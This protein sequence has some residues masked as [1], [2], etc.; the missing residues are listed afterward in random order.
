MSILIF[1]LYSCE[2]PELAKCPKCV[3]PL[4]QKIEEQT[5]KFINAFSASSPMNPLYGVAA[6]A[7]EAVSGGLDTNPATALKQFQADMKQYTTMLSDVMKW[8]ISIRCR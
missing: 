2:D 5:L 8:P 3:C 1:F 4:D 7:I 6:K